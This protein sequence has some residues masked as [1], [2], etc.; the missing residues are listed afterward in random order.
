ME[1]VDK[2]KDQPTSKFQVM[3]SSFKAIEWTTNK[4]GVI[5]LSFKVVVPLCRC[6]VLNPKKWCNGA[7]FM[8]CS[9]NNRVNGTVVLVVGTIALVT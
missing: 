3:T 5:A 4:F 9:T 8:H 2:S 7:S 1:Y 6:L